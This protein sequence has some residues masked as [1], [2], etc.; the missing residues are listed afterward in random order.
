MKKTTAKFVA[1]LVIAAMIVGGTVFASDIGAAKTSTPVYR[2]IDVS[3]HQGYIDWNT[4]KSQIDFAIIRCGYAANWTSQDDEQWTRNVSECERLGIPYGV[5]FYSYAENDAEAQGEADHALRLLEGHSPQLPVYLDLEEAR[6]ANCGN[7]QILSQTTIFCT[8]LQ[9]AGYNVGVYAS[10]YWWNTY[11]TSGAYDQW[12]RWIADWD[13]SEPLY[14]KPYD[15]WQYT[16]EGSVAGISGYVD[17][18]YWYGSITNPGST[19]TTM[20]WTDEICTP[21]ETD[22]YIHIK[23]VPTPGGTG[24]GQC[25]ITIKDASTGTVVGQKAEQGDSRGYP[26][27]VI[28]YNVTEELG[29]TLTP[30]KTYTYQIYA[31]FNGVRYDSPERTFT[32]PHTHTF[33]SGICTVCGATD[34]TVRKGDI[35]L[36]G[37]ITSADAVLLARYLVCT[38]QLN[39]A[40]LAAADLSGDGKVTSADAVLL[41]QELVR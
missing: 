37:V 25:G 32:T 19:E 11:L 16:S 10:R 5:Y 36:D 12:S 3:H 33:E 40:Q 9:A 35:N 38:A 24:F 31:Y 14:S 15:V 29:I 20:A 8:R 17:M 21:T 4:V 22:A 1:L 23:A 7:A 26:Y 13:R 27:I 39:D 6:I 41:A 18:N 2:G 30:G 28:W 34:E